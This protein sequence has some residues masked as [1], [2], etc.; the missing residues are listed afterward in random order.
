M[1]RKERNEAR[2]NWLLENRNLWCG[3]PVSQS[4]VWRS[5]E[6]SEREQKMIKQMKSLGLYARST[7]DIDIKLVSLINKARKQ[8]STTT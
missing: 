2:I 7:N 4:D 3:F 1:S 6:F 8:Y 5:K